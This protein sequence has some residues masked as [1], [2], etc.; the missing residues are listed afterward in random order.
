LI[1]RSL[2]R[3]GNSNSHAPRTRWRPRLP[4][5]RRRAPTPH[6]LV[7]QFDRGRLF[8]ERVAGDAGFD[9]VGP[10]PRSPGLLLVGFP[11]GV[12]SG[13]V[14]G[15]FNSG[16]DVPGLF[17]ITCRHFR[18]E[19]LDQA[20]F[21]VRP[22]PE[23]APPP[24]TW[25]MGLI[26]RSTLR[27]GNRS[28]PEDRNA[29]ARR[30][31]LCRNKSAQFHRL[32]CGENAGHG[33]IDFGHHGGNI[34]EIWPRRQPDGH[35]PGRPPLSGQSQHRHWEQPPRQHQLREI[36]QLQHGQCVPS[37]IG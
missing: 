37:V 15:V 30:L 7:Q 8:R 3:C 26:L 32:L 10:R 29:A 5:V 1:P 2:G 35:Q 20:N 33:N 16:T 28:N 6:R 21:G 12:V 14:L 34:M 24:V 17:G 9:R 13:L 4:R 11:S 25:R 27:R 18:H 22:V 36:G 19:S 31:P 23:F